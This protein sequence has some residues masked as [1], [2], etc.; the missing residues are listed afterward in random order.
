MYEVDTD[1]RTNTLYLT[2]AGTMSEAEMRDARDET[3]AAAKRLDSGFDIVND[4]STF[5][6]P[7]PEAAQP[8]KEA[9]KRLVEM[10]VDTTVRVVT[11]ETSAVV[12]N[13]FERRS[14]DA[15]YTGETAAS[16]AEAERI[17]GV[18]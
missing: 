15:G 16:V 14:R 17:L 5:A 4:I 8:I 11:D 7:S 10:G 13:A 2:L 18:A 3:V 1:R 12:T 9:Q 6:P